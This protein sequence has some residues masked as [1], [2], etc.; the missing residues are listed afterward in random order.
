MTVFPTCGTNMVEVHS[1]TALFPMMTDTEL[2]TLAEDIKTNGQQ[3]PI[4]MYQGQILDGRNRWKACEMAGVKPLVEDWRGTGSP[5]TWVI[6]VNLHRRHLTTS[7][8]ACIGVESL[9]LFEV[10]AKARML[11]GKTPDPVAKIPQGTGKARDKAADA[12]QVSPRSFRPIPSLD[13]AG[14]G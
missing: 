5:I 1:A 13:R 3:V 2:A 7:Q 4:T 9:S 6:S 11:A 12:V 8:R 14:H 10:E